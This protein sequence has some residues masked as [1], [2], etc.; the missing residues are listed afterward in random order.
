MRLKRTTLN[1][2]YIAAK[3]LP[4][5][6]SRNVKFYKF[7]IQKFL[8]ILGRVSKLLVTVVTAM[9]DIH[10]HLLFMLLAVSNKVVLQQHPGTFLTL[11]N[12]LHFWRHQLV[13]CG[14]VLRVE[15]LVN[16]H[17]P[18]L[19]ILH[20]PTTSSSSLHQSSKL[21]VWTEEDDDIN[22]CKI[23]AKQ[24]LVTRQVK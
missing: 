10:N 9:I 24:H 8:Q 12:P 22:L 5:F 13:L 3:V 2:E 15:K 14:E 21:V 11:A 20:S 7:I 6:S 23:N 4:C 18:P 19:S 17:L 16:L 1:I